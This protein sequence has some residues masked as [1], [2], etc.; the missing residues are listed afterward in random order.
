MP[1]VNLSSSGPPDTVL[2]GPEPDVAQALD[3]ARSIE[4]L[5][6]VTARFPA[7][8]FAWAALGEAVE[9]VRNGSSDDI[10]A[11]AF[12]R[13]GYHRGLDSLRKN[14][15]KGSGLVRWAEPSNRGFLRCL[16]GLSRMAEVI[17]EDDEHV[18]CAEFLRMLD[19]RWDSR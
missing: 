8:L 18:R 4:D 2:P 5:A 6:V 11:Y 19:P 16:D 1:D 13:I 17:G 10:A 12:F 15:W 7:S 14:G 9:K 3:A